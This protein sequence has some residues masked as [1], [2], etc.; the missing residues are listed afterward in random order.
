MLMPLTP[1]GIVAGAA[2]APA[3]GS[4]LAYA[5]WRVIGTDNNSEG[6]ARMA[7]RE[8]RGY[9]STNLSGEN[10]FNTKFVS[11]VYSSAPNESTR[12]FDNN[13]STYWDSYAAAA[14]NHRHIGLLMDNAYAIQSIE[15]VPYANI[16]QPQHCKLQASVDGIAWDDI[17]TFSTAFNTSANTQVLDV[18]AGA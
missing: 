4:P 11:A 10:L 18:Q 15:L 14:G 12:P 13:T 2:K 9:A 1:L 16:Y 8:I 3:G 7:W 6:N 17:I 5:Y